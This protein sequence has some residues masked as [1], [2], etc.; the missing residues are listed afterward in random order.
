MDGLV[1]S[2][3]LFSVKVLDIS[4]FS[5]DDT[6][7]VDEGFLNGNDTLS[8]V[9]SLEAVS[10]VLFSAF[11]KAFNVTSEFTSN[12]TGSSSEIGSHGFNSLFVF[13]SSLL[14]FSTGSLEKFAVSS[15]EVVNISVIFFGEGLFVSFWKFS[16]IGGASGFI[17]N[18]IN[19][20]LMGLLVPV[21]L[22][23]IG[24]NALGGNF[25]VAVSRDGKLL[26]ENDVILSDWF[27]VFSEDDVFSN[28]VRSISVGERFNISF[29]I[30]LNSGVVSDSISFDITFNG[31]E[32]INVP[33]DIWE[34]NLTGS[35][36]GNEGSSSEFHILKV[37]FNLIYY[38]YSEKI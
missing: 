6:V 4:V 27:V 17:L 31:F 22:K 26:E 36:G 1:D 21:S 18:A 33:V 5:L 2:L 11:V 35:G 10:V 16:E 3:D 25:F 23:N 38:N 28:F 19:H 15:F 24:V 20:N 30:S 13:G 7:G 9:A 29:I 37:W 14:K 32:F 12:L 8:A 34:S